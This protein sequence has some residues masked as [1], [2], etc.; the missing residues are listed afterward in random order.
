MKSLGECSQLNYGTR[1][2][3]IRSNGVQMKEL[4]NLQNRCSSVLANLGSTNR[5]AHVLI[6]TTIDQN[7]QNEPG[8]SRSAIAFSDDI[9]HPAKV[10]LPDLGRIKWGSGGRE[11]LLAEEKLILRTKQKNQKKRQN[12]FDDDEKWA[13]SGDRPFTKAKRSNCDVFDQNE[14]QTYVS[15]EKMLHKAIHA[16]RQLKKK[17]NTNTSPSPKQ[18]SVKPTSKAHSTRIGHYA[19]KCQKQ[20]PLVT[21]ENENVETEPEKED[22]LPI[23]DD[24]TYEP[25]E[26]L[27]EEQIR[28]HQANQEESSSIQKR[29]ELKRKGVMYPGSLWFF[30]ITKLSLGQSGF[31]LWWLA[32]DRGYIK[33]HSASLD[34]PF[35]P[36]QFQK[37]SGGRV[38]LLAE[39][40]PSLRTKQRNQR[41]RQN[42]FDDDEKWVR[43][44]DRPFTKARRSNCDVFDQNELQTYVN[45]EKMLHK[46]IHAIRQLK[47]KGN[48][49]TSPS[50]KHQSNFSSLSNSDLKTNGLSSDRSKAVKP[51]SKAHS[52][53]CFKCHRIGHYANKCQKQRPLVTLENE[54][55]ETE[56]EKEDPLP[57]FDDFTYEP[58][59]GL[60]EEQIR[61][62]KTNIFE[63]EGNDVPQFVDQ[64]IGTNQHGSSKDICSLFDSYLPKP[65]ASTHE[66]PWRM[67]ST[68]LRNSS[69]NNQIK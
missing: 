35:N 59:E 57:I 30:L 16:I 67:F 43:S 53:R 17:G 31:E 45:L 48:T 47:K 9:Q 58:M 5:Q 33:S 65:E 22:P 11:T 15:L 41:K 52:T 42:K 21:L 61:D 64:S 38:T 44:G 13:R 10:I 37:R 27:D 8:H 12:K 1:R 24:F 18:K 7:D 46:A 4:C 14:L 51:T 63:E 25:M 23:F 69:N 20:R 54:N 39:E 68:Q 26:E 36:S 62:L 29:T 34:D 19:N 56:L 55:V 60:D 66:I 6:V 40:K 49:N 2:T 32:L 3:R 50:P 28:G